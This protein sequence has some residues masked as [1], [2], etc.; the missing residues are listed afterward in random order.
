MQTFSSAFC[1]TMD[2]LSSVERRQ[3]RSIP[4][5][6]TIVRTKIRLSCFVNTN[7]TRTNFLTYFYDNPKI[8]TKTKT[9]M[10][11]NTAPGQQNI[12]LLHV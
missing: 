6:M 7:F 11:V 8:G 2:E 5:F 12:K 3:P 10:L 9:G 4:N 1:V